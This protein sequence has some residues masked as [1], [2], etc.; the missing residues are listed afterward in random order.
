LIASITLAWWNFG[1]RMLP[2][3]LRKRAPHISLF[4]EL[5]MLASAHETFV[6]A[7]V[8]QFSFAVLSV[9]HIPSFENLIARCACNFGEHLSRKCSRMIHS[10]YENPRRLIGEQS[11]CRSDLTVNALGVR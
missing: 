2:S 8:D 6:S 3:I 10:T 4:L 11:W 5:T 7:S 9:S 1:L